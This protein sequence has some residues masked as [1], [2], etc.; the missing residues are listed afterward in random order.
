MIEILKELNIL[1][2]SYNPYLDC[3]PLDYDFSKNP[4]GVFFILNTALENE[5]TYDYDLQIYVE[6]NTKDKMAQLRVIGEIQK[7]LKKRRMESGWI[8]PKNAHINHYKENN[9]DIYIL[10]Y[11]VKTYDFN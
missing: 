1:L 11:W 3:L 7:I 8:V 10:E 6:A 9:N 2:D 5:G 4:V